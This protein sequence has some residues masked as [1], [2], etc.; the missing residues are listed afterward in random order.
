MA[1]A[2]AKKYSKDTKLLANIYAQAGYTLRYQEFHK[3][4]LI[5][6]I[7]AYKTDKINNDTCNMVLSL[8]DIADTYRNLENPYKALEYFNIAKRLASTLDDKSYASSIKDQMASLYLYE[9]KD[10]DKALKLLKESDPYRDSIEISP[11][12][13]IY[14]ELYRITKRK[15]LH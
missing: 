14:S 13:S 6:F 11:A 15:T 1:E 4:S 3:R 12:L 7:N 10:A 2:S 5:K 8:R 9:L